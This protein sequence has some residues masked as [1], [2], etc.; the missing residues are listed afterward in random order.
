MSKVTTYS[1]YVI[2]L[3]EAAWS[4]SAFRGR[5]PLR[6]P[7]KPCAYVGMTGRTIELRFQQHRSGYRANRFARDHGVRLIVDRCITGLAREE[8]Q[9]EEVRTA[10][11]LRSEGWGVWQG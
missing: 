9:R 5:N 11:R 2:E 6:D 1:V 8:A 7:L 3:D 10:E 4:R